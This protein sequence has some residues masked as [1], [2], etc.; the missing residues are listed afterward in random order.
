M[1]LDE[2]KEVTKCMDCEKIGHCP[3]R[4]AERQVQ[5]HLWEYRD[6]TPSGEQQLQEEKTRAAQASSELEEVD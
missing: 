5:D 3:S 1:R 6:R 2:I 4:L